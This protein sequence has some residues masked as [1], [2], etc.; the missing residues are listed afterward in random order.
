MAYKDNN[1]KTDW[2]SYCQS[3]KWLFSEGKCIDFLIFFSNWSYNVPK[4]L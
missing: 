3:H 2:Y 1:G 4:K